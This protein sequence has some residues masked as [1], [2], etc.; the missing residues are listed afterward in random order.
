MLLVLH[1]E[2]SFNTTFIVMGFPGGSSGK[3]PTHQCRKLKRR[4]FNPWVRKILWRRIWQCTP[5]FLPG[6]S[7]R[8][9]SLVGYSL[10]GHK[11][12]DPTEVT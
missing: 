8:Q 9:R 1:R 10:Y 2:R 12:S 4:G 6:G 3:E 11:E 7:H 5:V